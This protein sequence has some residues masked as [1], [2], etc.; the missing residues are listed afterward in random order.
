M[1]YDDE[2]IAEVLAGNG[3]ALPPRAAKLVTAGVPAVV[4]N[5][6]SPIPSP[7]CQRGFLLPPVRHNGPDCPNV[8]LSRESWA[9]NRRRL[10]RRLHAFH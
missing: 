3:R 7:T 8:N 2:V 1:T 10:P 6:S 9:D 5:A 4:P